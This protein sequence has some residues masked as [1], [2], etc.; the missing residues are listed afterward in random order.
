MKSE[1][2]TVAGYIA[3]L[4]EIRADVISEIRDLVNKHIKSGFEETMRWGMITWEI[5][6]SLYPNTYNK[7]PLY[8]IGLAAQKN[9]YSLYLMSCYVSE[10]EGKEFEAAYKSSGKKMDIG[11]SCV[12][13]KKVADLPLPL[14]IKYIKRYSVKEFIAVHDSYWRK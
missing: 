3:S 13:F 5:P 1:E 7:Q 6:L 8:Y 9:N 2:K 11:K 14:I 12:R 10:K 4:P